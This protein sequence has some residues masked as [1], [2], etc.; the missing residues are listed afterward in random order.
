[1][2]WRDAVA[3][4]WAGCCFTTEKRNGSAEKAPDGG[5]GSER[6]WNIFGNDYL[7]MTEWSV[8]DDVTWPSYDTWP[9]GGRVT[10]TTL[11]V[12]SSIA[13]SVPLHCYLSV[14]LSVCDGLSVSVCVCVSELVPL[15]IFVLHFQLVRGRWV[16][17][18]LELHTFRFLFQFAKLLASL[19]RHLHTH[20]HTYTHKCLF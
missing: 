12:C 9:T 6:R 4:L 18:G 1:M 2:S 8:G 15:L 3:G 10:L 13:V 19:Q 14:S 16:C 17:L 11:R 7:F 5:G 20:I